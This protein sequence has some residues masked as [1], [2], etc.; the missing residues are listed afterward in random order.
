MSK[1]LG[2]SPEPIDLIDEYGADAVR[3]TLLYLSPLGQDVYYSEEKNEIGRNF[4]NK[5]WNAG[6]FLLM[7]KEQV[8]EAVPPAG[9]MEEHLDL[10]DRWIL[11]RFHST[12]RDIR[13]GLERYEINGIAKAIYEFLWHDYCDWYLEMIKSR[14]YGSE[15]LHV[16]QT[17]LARAVEVFDGAMRLLHPLMP[18][19]TEELW[20]NIRTR[21]AGESI[22]IAAIAKEDPASIDPAVEAEMFFVQSIIESLRNIRG[23]MGIP[24]GREISIVIRTSD[25]KKTDLITKYEGYLRQ[26]A[27]VGSLVPSRDGMRPHPAASAVVEGVE[28]YVPLAGLIDLEVER[29]RLGKE[30]GRVTNLLAGTRE[31]LGNEGFVNRAPEDVVRKEREKLSRLELDLEKLSR[32]LEAIS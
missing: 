17:V 30:I 31:K 12:T 3:F 1:S 11:S 22:M 7:N 32:N 23:E 4:A 15:P 21:N 27:R 25:E 5:I 8:G 10:A 13:Q 24:P 26:L 6:R 18:F 16:R 19:V 20:Q 14:L 2:N 29:S 9:K 28:V